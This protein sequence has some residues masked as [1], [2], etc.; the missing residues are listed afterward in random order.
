MSPNTT[1][2]PGSTPE[3]A[4]ELPE[5]QQE[6]A[7]L[8]EA[9]IGKGLTKIGKDT[10]KT[11]EGVLGKTAVN[12]AL[13]GVHK[14]EKLTP[15]YVIQ[16]IY[17]LIGSTRAGLAP[18]IIDQTKQPH[19]VELK[20][21]LTLDKVVR[22]PQHPEAR[23]IAW[24][25]DTDLD[26]NKALKDKFDML[27]SDVK[28]GTPSAPEQL[29]KMSAVAEMR[30]IYDEVARTD[31]FLHFGKES[32]PGTTGTG[33]GAVGYLEKQCDA[34]EANIKSL[35]SRR[36]DTTAAQEKLRQ[37]NSE[38]RALSRKK[39]QLERLARQFAAAAKTATHG[40]VPPMATISINDL[41]EKFQDT[42]VA[43]KDK[44]DLGAWSNNSV[45]DWVMSD[46]MATQVDTIRNRVRY[47]AGIPPA[48]FLFEEMLKADF[49]KTIGH[50]SDGEQKTFYKGIRETLLGSETVSGQN[51][52][53]EE[54]ATKASAAKSGTWTAKGVLKTG[55]AVLLSPF[56]FP[57][58]SA[59]KG[60]R[61]KNEGIVGS[62]LN[63]FTWPTRL[64]RGTANAGVTVAKEA[65]ARAGGAT[66]GAV[67][68]TLIFPGV[69]TAVG[70]GLGAYFGKKKEK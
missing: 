38:Q 64:M 2:T 69:G 15:P 70:A 50:L 23:A 16:N 32:A 60:L 1:N 30:K 3:S 26:G 55:A 7:R 20:N 5:L 31:E 48:S 68:G 45:A 12:N 25:Y 49:G 10:R 43:M 46:D 56:W 9:H 51:A 67:L 58:A 37:L 57:F 19:E 41:T 39:P 22:D 42:V 29:E 62:K 65:K 11:M 35:T 14:P 66:K 63:P 40:N 33:T 34:T 53:S 52:S 28:S 6:R 44:V 36:M 24:L 13:K 8:W 54:Q 61:G 4:T 21:K 17:R 27:S 18:Y 47:G 59:W